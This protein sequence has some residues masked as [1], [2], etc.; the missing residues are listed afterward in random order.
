MKYRITECDRST[1][2]GEVVC[3]TVSTPAGE[4]LAGY[5]GQGLCYIGF[6]IPSRSGAVADLQRRFPHAVLRF[7]D[8]ERNV[9]DADS[10]EIVLCLVGTPFQR[11]VWRALLDIPYG[12]RISYGELARRISLPEYG[13]AEPNGAGRRLGPVVRA[14]GRAVGANPIAVTVPCHRVVA[15]DGSLHGYYWGVEVKRRLL[16]AEAG[17]QR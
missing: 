16:E 5:C 10:G 14:V 12:G 17:G 7:D 3:C 8:G 11:R 6:C 2:A 4:A 1:F 13:A 9:P 15:A